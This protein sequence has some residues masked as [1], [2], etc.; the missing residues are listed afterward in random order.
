MRKFRVCTVLW[1]SVSSVSYINFLTNDS[2]PDRC[3]GLADS[4][5]SHWLGNSSCLRNGEI[6][7]A[8]GEQ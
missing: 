1:L 8:L 7:V 2:E 4:H 3:A 6:V 5:D